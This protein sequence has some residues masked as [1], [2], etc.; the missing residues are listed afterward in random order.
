MERV[1]VG[2]L[3]GLAGGIIIGIVSVTLHKIGI[4]EICLVALGGGIFSNNYLKNP[5]A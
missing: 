5:Q 1:T 2:F 4:C 3:A